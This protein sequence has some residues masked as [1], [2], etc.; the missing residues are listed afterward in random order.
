MRWFEFSFAPAARAGLGALVT[1]FIFLSLPGAGVAHAGEADWNSLSGQEQ[2]LLGRFAADWESLPVDRR[3]RLVKGARRWQGM[4]EDQRDTARTR[5]RQWRALSPDE[6]AS[7]R[8]RFQEFRKLP[9][10]ERK[11]IRRNYQYYQSLPEH[12]RKRLRAR[13]RQLTPEQR[14]AF[15]RNR[16]IQ[17]MRRKQKLQ[18]PRARRGPGVGQPDRPDAD[19][20]LPDR[21]N[22]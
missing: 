6:Q 8:K 21:D 15:L 9:M 16:D 2:R 11:R 12:E 22:Q 17:D 20:D 13:F 19:A 10:E 18:K 7:I 1:L 4:T 14:K 5:F 3:E